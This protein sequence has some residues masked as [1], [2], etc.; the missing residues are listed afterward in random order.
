MLGAAAVRDHKCTNY[1]AALKHPVSRIEPSFSPD[2]S[3]FD[4]LCPDNLKLGRC[5]SHDIFQV[6]PNH[7]SLI[8]GEHG[9]LVGIA[10]QMDDSA[11][12]RARLPETSRL[13]PRSWTFG[14]PSFGTPI[15]LLEFEAD[16][17]DRRG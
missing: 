16:G 9:T 7:G 10:A 13:A 3:P 6:G 4:V 17:A 15:R 14:P 8:D 12:C 5:V 2:R 1:G 11:L